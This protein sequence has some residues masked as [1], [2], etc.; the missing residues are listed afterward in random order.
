MLDS[1]L[2][3]GRISSLQGG[4]VFLADCVVVTV[5]VPLEQLRLI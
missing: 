2:P 1:F 3:T 5:V 4:F